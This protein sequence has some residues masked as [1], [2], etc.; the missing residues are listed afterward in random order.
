MKRVIF[1][2]YAVFFCSLLSWGQQTWNL[3][4]TMKA[5]L[6]DK[7]VLTIS[8]TKDSEDM[9]DFHAT[10]VSSNTPWY[11]YRFQ[12]TSVV[13]ENGV[14]SIGSSPFYDF[15]NLIAITI[16]N[17]VTSIRSNAFYMVGPNLVS[18][19]IPKS[20]SLIEFGAFWQ[21]LGLK[22]INVD[23]GNPAYSSEDGVLY[24]KDKT[25][26]LTYPRMKSGSFMIPNSVKRIELYAFGDCQEL[27]NI[28]I[29]NSVTSIG[30][31]AF[32]NCFKL[33]SV[34][35]PASV[36]NIETFAFDIASPNFTA[37]NVDIAN[38]AYSSDGGVF[39][40][41]DKSTLIKY[42]KGKKGSTFTIPNTVNRIEHFAFNV[43]DLITV[44][45]PNSVTYIGVG[46]FWCNA[47]LESLDIPASVIKIEGGA[48]LNCLA[49]KDVTVHWL[50]PVLFHIPENPADDCVH[51][52]FEGVNV[53]NVTLHVP[54]GTESIYRNTP[55]WKEFNIVSSTVSIDNIASQSLKA[56]SSNGNLN[57]SGLQPSKPL[58][59]YNLDG[60]LVYQGIAKTEE[61]QIPLTTRGIYIV[62]T[63]N[64]SI[65]IIV[66]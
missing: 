42:P 37:I 36:T 22:S 9:P 27:S 53:A 2:I 40:N 4:E 62:S 47:K 15:A 14:S 39:Y 44:E 26:L 11:N 23:T 30:R 59:I 66:K 45:I 33:T 35:I 12:V 50:E 10:S 65:K 31:D 43:S 51:H 29:P 48:F 28:E 46:A 41:K 6:D 55:G 17:S 49:L 24:D 54:Y 8:T 52:I 60:Q 20:V 38:P 7:G 34:S 63:V 21:C 61:V 18:I 13:I 19:T 32:A 5:T 57:I 1:L 56:F 64:Q 58:S 16:P 3:S 25:L